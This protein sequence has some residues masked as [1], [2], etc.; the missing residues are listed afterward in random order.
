MRARLSTGLLSL[1]SIDSSHTRDEA[2]GWA[3]P[4]L[5][6]QEGSSLKNGAAICL[7]S[8]A[9]GL[10]GGLGPIVYTHMYLLVLHKSRSAGFSR[11][12]QR[13]LLV[14]PR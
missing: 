9:P 2:A 12:F 1:G 7:G 11:P 5:S 8:S 4:L 13:S 6:I 10:S 3:L 14:S